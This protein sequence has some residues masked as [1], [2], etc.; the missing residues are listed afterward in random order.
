MNMNMEKST[1]IPTNLPIEINVLESE[2]VNVASEESVLPYSLSEKPNLVS[3]LSQF[4]E[5]LETIK[6]DG[7]V[8]SHSRGL[9]LCG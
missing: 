7:K 1:D 4:F 5:A 3:S 8:G 6:E 9:R 2:V